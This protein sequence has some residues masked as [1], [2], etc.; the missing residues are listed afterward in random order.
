MDSG[1]DE[2]SNPTTKAGV[3]DKAVQNSAVS[4]LCGGTLCQ[5]V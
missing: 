2:D 4:V 5:A 1:S 3:V